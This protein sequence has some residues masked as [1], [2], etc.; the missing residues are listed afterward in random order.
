MSTI[1]FLLFPFF[2]GV[3]FGDKSLLNSESV[4]GGD[5]DGDGDGLKNVR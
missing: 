2:R 1:F 5:G 3:S 4:G